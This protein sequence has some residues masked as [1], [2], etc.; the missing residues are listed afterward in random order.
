M[1]RSTRQAVRAIVIH[2]GK[3]VVMNRQKFGQQF[4]TLVGGG[5]DSGE[6]PEIALRREL[7]EETSMTVGTVR[8]V[9]V[10][11]AGDLFGEQLVFLCEY[12]GGNPQ[13][14]PNS[15]EAAITKLGQNLYLPEWL[16]LSGLP[17][18]VFRSDSVKRAIIEALIHGFPEMP[19]R[20]AWRPESVA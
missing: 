18:T 4:C 15:E 19:E 16:P 5:I 1:Q 14:S 11:D 3:L 9:F 20:L 13:L 10:E 2:D 17:N 8:L 7:M 6:T 12:I